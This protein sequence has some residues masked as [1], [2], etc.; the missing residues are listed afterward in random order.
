MKS[1]PQFAQPPRAA[2]WFVNLYVPVEDGESVAGDLHEEFSQLALK[3]GVAVARRWYWEQSFKTVAHLFANGF[4][5][6]PWS[7][8]VTVIAGFLL[9]QFVHSLPDKLLGVLTDKYLMYWSA[10]FQAYLWL[11]NGLRIEHLVG[12][13]LT[14]CVVGLVAKGREMVATTTL[15][16]VLCTMILASFAW[17]VATS[18]G[19]SFLWNLPGPFADPFALGIGGLIVRTRRSAKGT[20]PTAA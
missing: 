20:L 8:A 5:S 16:F 12:S 13:L 18:G 14:G 3:S 2:T 17:I 1:Q 10:H 4:R 9:L 15:I 11:L 19:L 7:M 6:A